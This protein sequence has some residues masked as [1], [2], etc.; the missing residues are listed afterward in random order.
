M[1]RAPA[2]ALAYMWWVQGTHLEDAHKLLLFKRPCCPKLSAIREAAADILYSGQPQAK[3]IR[4][5][6]TSFSKT[7]EVAGAR[8]P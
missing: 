1:G 7:V 8:G 3:T 4:K 2:V 6:G 5:N